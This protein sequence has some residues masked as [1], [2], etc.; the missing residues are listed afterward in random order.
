MRLGKTAW[1]ILGGG[2]FVIALGILIL[3][4]ARTSGEHASVEEELSSAQTL[5]PQVV[6]ERE[7]WESQLALVEDQ[8]DEATEAYDASR[9]RFPQEVDSIAYDEELFIIAHAHDLEIASLTVSETS[10]EDVLGIIFDTTAFEV[11]VQ[12][13]DAP[14]VTWTQGFIDQTINNITA[15]LNAVTSGDYFTNATIDLV[16]ILAP[17]PGEEVEAPTALVTLIIYSY[18][19]QEE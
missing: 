1:L 17:E 16:S 9:S 19:E 13:K 15:F 10:Q 2:I 18:Q 7:Y 14:H 11:Q 5:L 3:G 12:A 6:T 8:L 4:Y